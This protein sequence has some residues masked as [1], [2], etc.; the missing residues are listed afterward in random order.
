M[1][2]SRQGTEFKMKR[3]LAATAATGVLAFAGVASAATYV[4]AWTVSPT[5]AISVAFGDNGLDIPGAESIPGETTT[6]H[7]YDPV[8]DAFTDT[9]SFELPTGLVGFSLSSIGFASNT[10][11]YNVAMDFNGTNIAVQ[12]TANGSGGFSYTALSGAFNIAAG[13]PQLLTISGTGG[14][15]AVFSG[16]ATFEPQAAIPEP[17]AWALMILGF[18]GAGAMLRRGRNRTAFTA[19]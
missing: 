9:F 11:L 18:G 5:G 19:A 7:V 3:L 15:D 17:G 8:T 4:D 16:T 13:G 10:S 2:D 6:T 14:P 1:G 12:Q